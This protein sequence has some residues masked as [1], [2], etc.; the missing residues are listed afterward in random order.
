M[1]KRLLLFSFMGMI[2]SYTVLML[3]DLKLQS[4]NLN[5]GIIAFELAGNTN[6]S[7]EIINYW[8]ENSNQ[9]LAAFSVGFDYLFIVFYVGFL[10]LWTSIIADGF[11]NKLSNLFAKI[12]ITITIVAGMFD[13]I[14]NYS[15]IQLLISNHENN[16][17]VLA[18]YFASAK[19][20]ILAF[21]VL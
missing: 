13:M 15:L 11:Y 2:F 12:V 5:Y 21:V 19:F 10:A 16:W 9:N 7:Y 14:E 8:R 1:K 3:V 6:S 20:I 17:S 4:G 18:F